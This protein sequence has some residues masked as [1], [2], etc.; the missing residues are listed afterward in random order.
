MGSRKTRTSDNVA[1]NQVRYDMLHRALPW[2]RVSANATFTVILE[3]RN[4]RDWIDLREL[5]KLG[6]GSWMGGGKVALR[7]RVLNAAELGLSPE[8]SVELGLYHPQGIPVP[9]GT[10]FPPPP[11]RRPANTSIDDLVRATHSPP[12]LSNGFGV[13]ADWDGRHFLAGDRELTPLQLAAEIETRLGHLPPPPAQ[14]IPDDEKPPPE[15]YRLDNPDDPIVVIAPNSAVTPPGHTRSPAQE[16]AD[17]LGRPVLAPDSGYVI[18]RDG[19]VNVFRLPAP[20]ATA[21]GQ[22]W[23]QGNWVAFFP[24]QLPSVR[25]ATPADL[26]VI[27]GLEQEL[28]GGDAWDRETLER[29]F[30]KPEQDRPHLVVAELAGRVVGVAALRVDDGEATLATNG[31]TRGQQGWGIGSALRSELLAEARRRGHTEVF[32]QV[33]EDNAGVGRTL[34]NT[35]GFE[36]IGREPRY[37]KDG[38]AA[39]QLRL[40]LTAAEREGRLPAA[41]RALQPRAPRQLGYNLVGAMSR[42][43]QELRWKLA[44]AGL[45]GRLFPPPTHDVHFPLQTPESALAEWRLGVEAMADL[46]VAARKFVPE[47]GEQ[48]N[49]LRTALDQVDDAV[50]TVPR[51]PASPTD[52]D[53]ER[54]PAWHDLA[55]FQRAASDQGNAV[56][57]ALSP[58]ITQWRQRATSLSR[59]RD[60]ACS[61]L[62]APGELEP[63][64]AAALDRLDQALNAVP[65]PAPLV[66]RIAAEVSD[67]GLA[68]AQ[69]GPREHDF[70][71]ALA[72][73]ISLAIGAWHTRLT[74]ALSLAAA[75]RDL[76][77]YTGDQEQVLAER[78]EAAEWNL[79]G[80]PALSF[81]SPAGRDAEIEAALGA[82]GRVAALED[83]ASAVLA[84]AAAAQGPLSL[85]AASPDL[86]A[87]ARE[88]LPHTGE[89]ED[90]LG[91]R[92]DKA[93]TRL[94]DATPRWWQTNGAKLVTAADVQAAKEGL[95]GDEAGLVQA[96]AEDFQNAVAAVAT[97]ANQTGE[98]LHRMRELARQ[99][100]LAVT[101]QRPDA[102]PVSLRAHAAGAPLEFGVRVPRPEDPFS[103]LEIVRDWPGLRVGADAPAA[104]AMVAATAERTRLEPSV[105]RV[106]R[107]IRTVFA[108]AAQAWGPRR[109]AALRQA[110]RVRELLPETGERLDE[111]TR[112]LNGAYR[113][114]SAARVPDHPA[115]SEQ[116]EAAVQALAKVVTRTVNL[117]SAMGSVLKVT[118]DWPIRQTAG[119]IAGLAREMSRL[120]PYTGDAEAALD[121]QLQEA[122]PDL[123]LPPLLASQPAREESVTEVSSA[124][125]TLDRL[126]TSV[127]VFAAAVTAA[128]HAG[129]QPRVT[130]VTALAQRARQ[131]LGTLANGR[132]QELAR[133][134]EAAEQNLPG[135][136]PDLSAVPEAAELDAVRQ[137]LAGVTALETVVS[138]VLVEVGRVLA[139]RVAAATGLAEAMMRAV[140]LPGA[141]EHVL[142]AHAALG[143]ALGNMR[144]V[145]VLPALPSATGEHMEAA[146]S[147]LTRL[148][149]LEAATTSL[150]TAATAAHDQLRPQV[151]AAERAAAAARVVQRQAG[152]HADPLGR[153]LTA[154]TERLR[155]NTPGWWAANG[156]LGTVPQVEAARSALTTGSADLLDAAREVERVAS[157]VFADHGLQQ[158]VGGLRAAASDLRDLPQP[159]GGRLAELGAAVRAALQRVNDVPA[160]TWAILAQGWPSAPELEAARTAA[161]QVTD[162]ETV[163][164]RFTGAASEFA[165]QRAEVLMPLA[166]QVRPLVQHTELPDLRG[167]RL[168]T[169]ERRV[170]ALLSEPA[171]PEASAEA[172][173]VPAAEAA[174][175]ARHLVAGVGDLQESL[176]IVLTEATAGMRDRVAAA[177][178]VFAGMG[179]DLPITQEQQADLTA[180][181]DSLLDQGSV[182]AA[183][184]DTGA[185]VAV[186]Q[187]GMIALTALE[188]ASSDVPRPCAT[189]RTRAGCPSPGQGRPEAAA[190][191]R[192]AA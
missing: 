123:V 175:V 73:A 132:A 101:D 176:E 112:G 179:T 52:T 146:R 177:R 110:E 158:T 107:V 134:L 10:F 99:H 15:A 45:P 140:P 137:A 1:Q 70:A 156:A 76:L 189:G 61:L 186:V 79:P 149:Q 105:Q 139:P 141:A 135:Q 155:G 188:T 81:D 68:L 162:L 29:D 86:E 108:T 28:F 33:R 65:G 49:D 34:L 27:V 30:A 20:D 83:A 166:E 85:V 51:P 66:P 3:A 100:F 127:P 159:A 118:I 54:A 82:F 113:L 152:A 142:I 167:S 97:A 172:V 84:A 115:T 62:S 184:A 74:S 183:T 71:R 151:D 59:L 185:A 181:D 171:R 4:Q 43:G 16:L 93:A 53:E 173:D 31:V 133:E 24:S 18:G 147:G 102:E 63:E 32:S 75:A 178:A 165:R 96:A 94:R 58:V 6:L 161:D 154:V 170:S 129:W 116:M 128:L 40:D 44:V 8:K 69:F 13:Q 103:G 125:E 9:S 192:G 11:D 56:A 180:L 22:G 163:I 5:V 164:R 124:R 130:A 48:G 138:S 14:N 25:E 90:D 2:L 87:A 64:L 104:A 55:R 160:D 89:Q 157:Q 174:D 88:M 136:R 67:A 150:R 57:A 36:Q 78:L 168:S 119:A 121:Q 72:Q 190:Y 153:D 131:L 126:G 109:I 191:Q 80:Q 12:F 77:P 47:P 111:L 41:G 46:A 50:R 117:E 148:S 19:S 37:Y 187:R 60:R 21:Y 145:S 122:L 92:L 23:E 120:L 26:D 17:A 182:V 95:E 143:T 39:L 144:A 7:Y 169:A 114:V 42:A 38:T 106:E 98:R 35:Y 91:D